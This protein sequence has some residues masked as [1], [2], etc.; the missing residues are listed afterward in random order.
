MNANNPY[1]LPERPQNPN[2][3]EKSSP[4]IQRSD[5]QDIRGIRSQQ[6]NGNTPQALITVA[7]M[8]KKTSLS[9]LS[10]EQG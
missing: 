2:L 5:R 10:K 9:P 6:K 8:L 4:P 3:I 1:R 7:N